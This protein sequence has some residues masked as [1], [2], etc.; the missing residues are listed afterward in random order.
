MPLGMESAPNV[1]LGLLQ[2]SDGTSATAAIF[3]AG[4]SGARV[5]RIVIHSGPTTAPGGTTNVVILHGTT[6]IDVFAMTNAVDTLQYEK[7]FYNMILEN[8]ETIKLQ[9][10][11][12][13]A[14]GATLHCAVYGA[15]F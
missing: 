10:R 15:D 6:I 1:G 4:A 2:N 12:A 5:E 9:S 3:T 13:V 14:S 8:A 7:V 11:T